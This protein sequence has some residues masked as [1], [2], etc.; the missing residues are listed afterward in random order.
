MSES[1]LVCFVRKNRNKNNIRLSLVVV[2]CQDGGG[3]VF[4]LYDDFCWFM[5]VTVMCL[6]LT[7][8]VCVGVGD[9]A[10]LCQ[11]QCRCCVRV[12][13]KPAS[14]A[15]GICVGDGVGLCR[16]RIQLS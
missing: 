14:K 5:S 8:P 2:A 4:G 13:S 1:T 7:A 3:V 9:G 15:F 16:C 12:G 10:G 6:L 11:Q